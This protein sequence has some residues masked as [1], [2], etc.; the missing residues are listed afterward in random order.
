MI[1][2]KKHFSRMLPESAADGDADTAPEDE[3]L[4]IHLL[5]HPEIDPISLMAVQET[6]CK[7]IRDQE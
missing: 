4:M 2:L 6:L 3:L 7:R 5:N 1:S